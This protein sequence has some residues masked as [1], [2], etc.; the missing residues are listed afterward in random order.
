MKPYFR[1]VQRHEAD[2]KAALKDVYETG[3]K[4]HSAAV[5]NGDVLKK[6][7]CGKKTRSLSQHT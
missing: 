3:S 4:A 7:L 6:D 5:R 1:H 2:R